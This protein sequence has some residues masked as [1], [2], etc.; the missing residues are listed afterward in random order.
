MKTRSFVALVGLVAGASSVGV[1]VA[2]A[3]DETSP[4]ADP[5]GPGTALPGVD[6]GLEASPEDAT[7]GV[8]P[9]VP[10]TLCPNG[11]FDPK[12]PGGGLDTRTRINVV[13][14]RS[15]SDV[16][17]AGAR[18]AV[19][20]FDGT[21]WKKLDTGT[22]ESLNALWLRGSS[23]IAI[24]SVASVFTR[25]LDAEDGGA[26][27][28]PPSPPS[29]GGWTDRGTP[30]GPPQ[31]SV[32]G[33][34]LTSSWTAPGAEWL[35]C[36]AMETLADPAVSGL[37]RLRVDP[38]TNGLEIRNA[39]PRSTCNFL[40][41]KKMMSVHGSSADD[42]WAV[43][44]T[45]AT[46]RITNAQ[47]E[48]PSV[49]AYDSQTWAGLSGVWTASETEA[50]AVGGAGVIRHYTGQSTSWDVVANVP[51]TEDL[52]AVWGSSASDVWAVGMRGVVLHYDGKG[53]SLVKVT[54][55][56]ART[57]DLH[58]VWTPE[59]GHV[60]IG[61]EGVLLSLGGEP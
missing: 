1:L 60:W 20:H 31:L 18:G 46:F 13:R 36:T 30:V 48:T 5:E 23:E 2:C 16:W 32:A 3:S 49:R 8:D 10:G 27:A 6:A 22:V 34:L 19:A 11:L 26:D 51:T 58:A 25:G 50:W 24:A 9:C 57:P 42:L 44:T 61:G 14:G 33:K 52:T 28:A 38:S 39:V 53:W 37:W 35:W 4:P 7:A 40:P 55:L 17:I 54:G 47:G 59:P 45:G 12:R 21:S 29:A 41:C 43:G 56:G 15:P